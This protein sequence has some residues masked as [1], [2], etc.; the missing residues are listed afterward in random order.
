MPSKKEI[1][2]KHP[3]GLKRQIV[4]DYY[5]LFMENELMTRRKALR[6]IQRNWNMPIE[7]IKSIIDDSSGRG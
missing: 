3:K 5:L 4:H 6:T 2:E 7:R 1:K